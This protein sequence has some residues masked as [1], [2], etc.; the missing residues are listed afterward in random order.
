MSV[1]LFITLLAAAV[2]ITAV[3]RRRG[4]QAPLVVVL[5][6]S[7]V[8]FIPGLPEVSIDSE[9]ILTVV[10]PPLLYSSALGVSVIS[11]SKS[12]R[13]ITLLGVVLVVVTALVVGAVAFALIP[14]LTWPAAL[15][16]GAIIAPPDAVSAASIGRKLGLPRRLM[17]VMLGESLINDATS[18]T[19]MKVALTIVGGVVLTVTEDVAIFGTAVLVGVG[20]GLVLGILVNW[21]RRWLDDPVIESLLSLLVPFVAYSVA[22]HL[23]GSGVLAVVTAG[24]YIG[25]FSPTTGYRTRLQEEPLWES[26]DVLLESFVFTLIGLQASSVLESM[27]S[28]S[29]GLSTMMV[30]AGL[31]LLATILVRPAFIFGVY[32]L[33]YVV[34]RVTGRHRRRD[35]P[36]VETVVDDGPSLLTRS[37]RVITPDNSRSRRFA[38]RTKQ[39]VRAFGGASDP[40]RWS[41]LVVL[42]WAGMRGV[43]TLAAAIGV[44]TYLSDGQRF[45]AHDTIIFFA[46]TATIGTLLLQGLTLPWLIRVLKVA[47][48]EQDKRD[49][50]ARRRLQQSTLSEATEF[51][52][53]KEGSW[54]AKYGD[55]TVDRALTVI[56]NRLGRIERQLEASDNPDT[57]LLTTKH[58]VELRRQVIEARRRI[59]LRERNKGALDEEVMRDL[60]RGLDAEEL[61]L[62]RTIPVGRVAGTTLPDSMRAK[63]EAHPLGSAQV[64]DRGH[65]PAGQTSAHPIESP[66]ERT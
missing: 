30:A 12:F 26:L 13:D 7:V 35:D 61:A 51:V 20:I 14:D 32:G 39:R 2:V 25:Y 57:A 43:V 60:M 38:M 29:R 1:I 17:T 47:D 59:L 53:Q 46:F 50:A 22:E 31:V 58:V 5:V 55:A 66:H 63:P 19:L 27:A 36:E 24:L 9:V 64:A 42:S 18:L 65:A 28:S 41:E 56:Q 33:G 21:A 44:P 6:A 40:L 15:L 8:S 4:L 3:A 52:K 11:F 45:P 16:I 48:P 49:R 37:I 23:N 62:D 10:L 54:R 34:A